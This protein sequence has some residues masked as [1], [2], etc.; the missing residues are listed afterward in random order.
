MKRLLILAVLFVA[1]PSGG[2]AAPSG[3]P[4]LPP[5]ARAGE[6]VLYGHIRS[7]VRKGSRYEMRLDPAWWLTGVA[8]QRAAVEDRAIQPGEPVPNDYYIVEGGHRLLTFPVAASARASIL[9][10]QKLPHSMRTTVPRL[11]TLVEGTRFG[12]WVR[13]NKRGTVIALDQQYQP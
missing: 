5:A 13:L 6:S 1:V 8:A 9:N 11:T 4:L 2:E 7:L 3:V 10:R 12:F